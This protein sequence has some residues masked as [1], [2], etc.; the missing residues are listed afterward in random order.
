MQEKENL[1]SE[2]YNSDLLLNQYIIQSNG[3]FL[4]ELEKFVSIDTD[5]LIQLGNPLVFKYLVDTQRIG[6]FFLSYTPVFADAKLLDESTYAPFFDEPIVGKKAISVPAFELLNTTYLLYNLFKK[7]NHY[8]FKF[9]DDQ[10]FFNNAS[11]HPHYYQKYENIKIPENFIISENEIHLL[12]KFHQNYPRFKSL[13]YPDVVFDNNLSFDDSLF[14]EKRYLIEHFEKS[15]LFCTIDLLMNDFYSD[16]PHLSLLDPELIKSIIN[17]QSLVT[18]LNQ[19]IKYSPLPSLHP[20]IQR[21]LNTKKIDFNS[22]TSQKEKDAKITQQWIKNPSAIFNTFKEYT[23][24]KTP[25]ILNK[26]KLSSHFGSENL[27]FI[28]FNIFYSSPYFLGEYL[29]NGSE[30]FSLYDHAKSIEPIYELPQTMIDSIVHN[31]FFILPSR[32]NN[33]SEKPLPINK[34]I[35]NI[36]SENLTDFN[37]YILNLFIAKS[38]SQENELKLKFNLDISDFQYQ[39]CFEHLNQDSLPC[40]YFKRFMKGINFYDIFTE[41]ESTLTPQDINFIQKNNFYF[42]SIVPTMGNQLFHNNEHQT[43]YNQILFETTYSK[44]KNINISTDNLG[45]YN[46]F[47]QKLGF[48]SITP[49][50]K[51]LPRISTEDQLYSYIEHFEPEVEKFLKKQNITNKSFIKYLTYQLVSSSFLYKCLEKHNVLPFLLLPY[52]ILLNCFDNE[53]LTIHQQ[54]LKRHP[55]KSL[56]TY[57]YKDSLYHY[58]HFCSTRQEAFDLHKSLLDKTNIINRLDSIDEFEKSLLEICLLSSCLNAVT[59]YY[60]TAQN[61]EHLDLPFLNI[62]L[63]KS[64][65]FSYFYNSMNPSEKF[66]EFYDHSFVSKLIREYQ[67]KIKTN[68]DKSSGSKGKRKI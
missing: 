50:F 26:D 64:I 33:I 59:L 55:L 51:E 44:L 65:G 17:V 15:S 67:L 46:F 49:F 10:L 56:D 68:D 30:P 37:Q 39:I 12:I 18:K 43:N 4:H 9:A 22:L 54:I 19:N 66:F 62:N 36:F 6:F 52:S 47:N 5:R 25:I 3:F 8:D 28:L 27:D 48:L 34:K 31:N 7:F 58:S 35:W 41:F 57:G 45:D 61:N 2:I 23:H 24:G 20:N 13:F 14:I 53:K 63:N 1:F 11:T 32:L 60:K 42:Y 40:S 16:N 38:Y 21:S 29:I